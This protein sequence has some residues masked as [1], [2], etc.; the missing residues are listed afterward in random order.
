MAPDP[1]VP[2]VFTPVKLITVIEGTTFWDSVAVTVTLLKTVA[3]NA[4]QISAVP[5]CKLVL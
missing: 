5:I 3:A 2:A 1:F 4:L